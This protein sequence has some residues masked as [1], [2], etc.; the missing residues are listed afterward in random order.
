MAKY[1]SLIFMF[2]IYGGFIGVLVY[3]VIK[4]IEDK[5][6]EKFEKRDN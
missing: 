2:L 3:L 1:V 4:R 6:N 5:K